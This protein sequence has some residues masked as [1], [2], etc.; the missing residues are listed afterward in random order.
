MPPRKILKNKIP[1]YAILVYFTVKIEQFT[2]TKGYKHHAHSNF[3]SGV[4]KLSNLAGHNL[5]S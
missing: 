4:A 3:Y 5:G 2:H 1:T